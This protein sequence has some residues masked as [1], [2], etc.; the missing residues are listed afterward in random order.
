MMPLM[1]GF[2]LCRNLKTDV[3]I[4]HIPVILLT[5]RTDSESKEYGY[6]LGADAYIS[7]PFSTE[8]LLNV[9]YNIVYN[10]NLIKEHFGKLE[11]QIPSPVETTFSAADEDFINKVNAAIRNNISNSDL[12]VALICKEVGVSR[13]SLYNKMKAIT[14]M[15]AGDYITRMRLDEA[16]RLIRTT[17]LTFAEIADRTGFSTARYFSTIF[18]QHTGKTPTQ[19]KSDLKDKY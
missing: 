6:K 7:K 19:Y 18:K 12:D 13:A 9:L 14:D 1:N 3:S 11:E 4:S 5:A 10:R 17:D 16:I 8:E 2:E 15:G